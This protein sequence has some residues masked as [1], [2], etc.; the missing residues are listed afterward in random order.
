MWDKETFSTELTYNFRKQEKT[1]L[2]CLLRIHKIYILEKVKKNKK[3]TFL[4][5]YLHIKSTL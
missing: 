1:H 2:Y 5:K 4:Q 3:T